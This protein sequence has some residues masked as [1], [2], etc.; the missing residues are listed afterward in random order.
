MKTYTE[1]RNKI[2]N[3]CNVSTSDTV[4]MAIIDTNLNDSI[5]TIT[6]LQGGKLRFLEATK[7]MFTVASQESYQI[8]NGFRKLIDIMVYSGDGS[9]TSDVIY[10]PEMVFDPTKWKLVLQY[11]F[12]TQDV[13]YFIYVENQ[14]FF[15]QPVP[16]TDGNLIR[17]RGRL[18]VR[19][20][21]IADYTTGTITS[22]PFTTTFTAIV[23]S[24]ATSATLSG[25]WGLPTGSYMVTFSNGEQR[26]VTLTSAATTATWS[27]ALT[28]AA[29]SAI[30]VGASNGGSIITASGTAFTEDMVGR[31]IRITETTA[32]NGG[33]G[34][35]YQ[36]GDYY[37]A[38]SVA[39]LKPYEGVAIAAGSATFTLG[40]C[41]VI[42]E[43]YD[44]AIVWRSAAVW[45]DKTDR[46]KAK[47]YWL[48][49]DGGN[50]AG[51][52]KDYGG[53]IG[54][55]LD[56]EGETEEGSYIPPF[57]STNP[58]PTAPYYFPNQQA[59]GL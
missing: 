31:Y 55:M 14:K 28:S 15:I 52:R 12:G 38:T 25:A 27:T 11:K 19:D 36:I 58:L 41:S 6:N 24:G 46:E 49:Y 50:E 39:L 57:G 13:P 18:Q 23:A 30:T 48:K 33:D 21:S 35:W 9:S 45:W 40:Q 16:S 17:L 32:A 20:L 37:S 26:S 51:Y 22:I 10:S 1:L 8:P 2:A 3:E 4:K 54:Q 44:V 43:A 42:P 29:T 34:F 59:S 56:N 53:L 7:D 47:A 5:R